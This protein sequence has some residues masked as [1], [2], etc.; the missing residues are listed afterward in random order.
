[1]DN[2]RDTRRIL[3]LCFTL[4]SSSSRPS[5]ELAQWEWRSPRWACSYSSAGRTCSGLLWAG[6]TFPWAV[7][8][9][10]AVALP[11]GAFGFVGGTLLIPAALA[12]C[13]GCLA[14]LAV[15]S[16]TLTLQVACPDPKST[17]RALAPA[18]A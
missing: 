13:I 9:G 4:L 2:V 5:E 17:A 11:A 3:C 12:R 16:K 6:V 8:K 10:A 18:L 1:M 15:R 14:V 7:L